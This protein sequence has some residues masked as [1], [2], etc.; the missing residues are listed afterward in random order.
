MR[1]G[2]YMIIT[3]LLVLAMSGCRSAKT[4]GIDTSRTVEKDSV[5]TVRFEKKI[6]TVT[7]PGDTLKLS[8][9]IIQLSEKPIYQT[10]PS[11]RTTASVRRVNDQVEVECFV[12]EYEAIIESQNQIIETLVN[13]LQSDKTHETV[14]VTKSPW[15]MKALASLGGLLLAFVV[16]KLVSKSINPL[17]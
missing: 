10:T 13:V 16:Y 11:G 15:Y 17:S 6:D 4:I 8:V 2:N 9:P 7:I 1:L 14:E 5:T 12:D 3:L